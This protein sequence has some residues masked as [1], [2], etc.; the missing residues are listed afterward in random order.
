MSLMSALRDLFGQADDSRAIAGLDYVLAGGHQYPL[1]GLNQTLGGKVEDIDVGYTSLV[2]RAYMSNSVVYACMRARRDLFTEARFGFQ[3]MRGGVAGDFFGDRDR[4]NGQL[5]L[6]DHPWPG[7]TTGDLLKYMLTDNDL[8]G[9]AFIAKR[10]GKL[11]RM[12]PDWTRIVHGSP[13]PDGTMWDPEAVLLGYAYQP[14]GPGLGHDW[15]NFLPEEVAHFSTTPDPLMPVRGMSWLSPILREIMADEAMTEHRLKFFENGGTPN[16]V[17]KTGYTD[18]AK[19]GEF[20]QF[21]RQNHAGTANA[22]KMMG[23]TAGVDATVVGADLKQLDFKVVQG[24]GE[25]RIASAAGVPPMIAGLSE[26]LQ[27]TSLNAGQGFAPSMRMFA[28]LTMSPAWRN[29]AGSLESI[30]RPPAGAR[31]WYDIRGIPAL[32]DDIRDAAEVRL[33][34]AGA[35]RQLLDA[36]FE[37]QTVVD[38]IIA[39]DWKR[40]THTGLYSVQLQ[41]PQ[42]EGPPAPPPVPALPPGRSAELL[43]AESEARTMAVLAGRNGHTPPVTNVYLPEQPPP[44]TNVYLPEPVTNVNLPEQ[45]APQI[46]VEAPSPTPV[47]VTVEAPP[48]A[49]VT[50]NVPDQEP[51]QVTVNVPRSVRRTIERDA[52]GAIVAI[53]EE[54]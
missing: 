43:V 12:R 30:V 48:P 29:A 14:G 22:Y 32:K 4:P 35:I 23:F 46:T 9:N 26:G 50:V 41:P 8:A 47:N 52:A 37:P 10:G 40:L 33:K 34:D 21:L 18:I 45:P 39:N 1:L 44:V 51:P 13:D 3:N 20:M 5:A 54:A 38:A 15:I 24:A 25:T 31:L 6:L 42:P 17:I 49:E 11:F 16:L 2:W 7:A 19:L 27:G 53:V 36:G 28:D